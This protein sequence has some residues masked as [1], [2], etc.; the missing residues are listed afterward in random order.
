MQG[1]AP[2]SL[3]LSQFQ[4]APFAT[5][6]L[7]VPSLLAS[8]GLKDFSG[9]VN[10]EFDTQGQQGLLMASYSVDQTNTYVFEV[11]PRALSHCAGKSLSYRSTGNG[12]DTMVP[13]GIQPMRRRALSSGYSSLGGIT[14]VW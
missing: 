10:L 5:H 14:I 3:Q 4:L 8:A 7:D 13:S 12:D 1:N 2:K 9:S 11:A 6:S